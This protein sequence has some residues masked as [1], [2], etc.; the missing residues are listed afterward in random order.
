MPFIEMI[1]PFRPARGLAGPHRQ[2]FA[3]FFVSGTRSRP[4]QIVHRIAL[5]DGDAL[6]VHEDRPSSEADSK[7]LVIL[8]HGL[9]GCHDSS[10]IRRTAAKLVDAGFLTWRMDLRGCGAGRTWARRM[11]NAARSRDI[12]AVVE[13][14]AE[15]HPSLLVAV[16]GYSL[17]GNL[18]LK[19]LAEEGPRPPRHLDAALAVAPPTDV[20][21]CVRRLQQGLSRLYD[22]FFSRQLWHMYRQAVRER[23]L[24]DNGIRRQPRSLL[25]FDQTVTVPLNGYESVDAYYADASSLPLLSRISVATLV[26]IAA[27]DPLV[28]SSIFDP[29]RL[30][31]STCLHVAAGGG[32]LGFLADSPWQKDVW[33]R[34]RQRADRYWLDWLV[35][36]W[37][38]SLDLSLA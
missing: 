36:D 13:Y 25:E 22:K 14:A 6:A 24:P 34:R 23:L 11:Y 32:H 28:P 19:Y 30:S 35:V 9:A 2:T 26:L 38:R 3:G 18:V 8:V 10:Y 21:Q 29:L 17:G 15:E 27:D 7:R 16:A 12:A 33:G 5:P 31:P 1:P 37:A 20:R 4:S